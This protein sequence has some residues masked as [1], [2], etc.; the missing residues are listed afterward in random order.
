MWN[1]KIV[2]EVPKCG[3]TV[4]ATVDQVDAMGECDAAVRA[5][6]VVAAL[7]SAFNASTASSRQAKG[8]K[9]V[10]AVKPPE[11]DLPLYSVEVVF[12]VPE[13]RTAVSVLMPVSATSEAAAVALACARLGKALA[14]KL[15]NVVFS[16]CSAE[17]TANAPQPSLFRDGALPPMECPPGEPTSN[18]CRCGHAFYRHDGGGTH[19]P[20]PYGRPGRCEACAVQHGLDAARPECSQFHSRDEAGWAKLS[21]TYLTT[22]PPGT[23]G[24]EA[25]TYPKSVVSVGGPGAEGVELVGAGKPAKRRAKRDRTGEAQDDEPSPAA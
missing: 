12:V 8:V 14:E 20:G 3:A 24:E 10:P 23:E 18:V 17:L 5:S 15:E 16:E 6:G 9:S 21:G 11:S 13:R 7:F 25:D 4:S 19:G 22:A 2:G 1:C